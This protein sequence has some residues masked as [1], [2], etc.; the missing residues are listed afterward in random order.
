[1]L[2]QEAL[3]DLDQLMSKNKN[4]PFKKNAWI[5]T[6]T[7]KKFH[8]LDPSLSEISIIDIAHALSMICRFTGHSKEFYSVAQHCVLVS[9]ICDEKDALHGLLHDASEAYLSDI[10]KP[11]KHSGFFE[12][13]KR[14]EHHLQS[15]IFQKFG[16]SMEE[17]PGVKKADIILLATEARDLMSP[18]HTDWIQPVN[19]LP[20]TIFPLPPKEAEQL[21]LNRFEELKV[22]LDNDI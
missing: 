5:Q 16:L 6:F 14:I 15:M 1:M 21:F 2:V 9:Y 17:P 20:F 3:A 10:S 4:F 22:A 19:P 8:P 13:Y 12:E 11:L 7:G 18:L